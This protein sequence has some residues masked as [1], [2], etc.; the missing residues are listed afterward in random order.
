M[1]RL[2]LHFFRTLKYAY[3]FGGDTDTIG[4]MA[5]ALAGAHYGL[6]AIP[7]HLVERCEG[8][9]NAERQ[10]EAL[11][12][13]VMKREE[14]KGIVVRNRKMSTTTKKLVST[15]DWFWESFPFQPS[16]YNTYWDETKEG[17]TCTWVAWKGIPM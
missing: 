9:E 5:G 2:C 17:Q 14:K 7:R 4:S 6:S 13:A 15:I 10:G 1:L 11:Y 8:A 16:Y 3:A 12:E